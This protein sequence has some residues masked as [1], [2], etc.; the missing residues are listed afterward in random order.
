MPFHGLQARK[1]WAVYWRR[2]GVDAYGQPTTSDVA[3]EVRVRWDGQT[4]TVFGPNGDPVTIDATAGGWEFDPV[5]GSE[6]WAGRLG[7]IP[8]TGQRPST[9]VFRIVGVN[10][11]P[12]IRGR[13]SYREATLVRVRDVQGT[14]VTA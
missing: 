11:T 2:V 9:D 3:V 14:T 4:R 1:Q 7:D 5:I 13:D 10:V 6:V 12:D 8:G